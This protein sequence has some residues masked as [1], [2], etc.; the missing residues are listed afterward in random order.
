MR[1]AE[2]NRRMAEEINSLIAFLVG[3]EHEIEG[4]LTGQ[5]LNEMRMGLHNNRVGRQAGE[6][7]KQVCPTDLVTNPNEN[8][9]P[10]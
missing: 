9:M 2:W 3:W 6:N 7:G 8:Q 5:P 10:Y 1:H 4:L